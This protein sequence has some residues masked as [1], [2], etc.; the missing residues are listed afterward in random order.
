[1]KSDETTP[2]TLNPEDAQP[3]SRRQLRILMDAL[4]VLIAYVDGEARYRFTN[5][6][7]REWY[8]YEPGEITGKTMQEV[9]GHV[10]YSIVGTHVRAVLSGQQARFE[11]DVPHPRRGLRHICATYVP[12]ILDSGQARGFFSLDTDITDIRHAESMQRRRLEEVARGARLSAAGPGVPRGLRSPQPWL[13]RAR[14]SHAG[15]ERNGVAAGA[16][17]E[18]RSDPHRHA[19]RS[20]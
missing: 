5:R 14:H 4:P 18:T 6:A 20:R 15:H 10:A 7:H 13:Y 11:A 16:G 8:G 9:L 3:E 17:S 1:M 19:H 12:D 2:A